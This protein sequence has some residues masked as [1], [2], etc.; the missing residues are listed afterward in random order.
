MTQGNAGRAKEPCF[1]ASAGSDARLE[2]WLCRKHRVRGD[3]Y[4]R[5][6]DRYLYEPLGLANLR[7]HWQGFAWAKA[8]AGCIPDPWHADLPVTDVW[9][10]GSVSLAGL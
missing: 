9:A 10:V 6:L 3:G 5:Y 8:L 1:E 7:T 4:T 2:R